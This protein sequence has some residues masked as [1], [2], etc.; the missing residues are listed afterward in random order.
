[1][2]V[3]LGSL[4]GS[5][6]D[7]G[8]LA[9][10]SG[11]TCGRILLPL[12]LSD[13]C[14][15]YGVPS[16]VDRRRRSVVLRF[17]VI[18]TEM[19]CSLLLALA[20]IF[21]FL[22]VFFVVSV[23]GSA[24]RWLLLEG[25]STMVSFAGD[26]TTT[27][28]FFAFV[29]CIVSRIR[30]VLLCAGCVHSIHGAAGLATTERAA[31]GGRK[32]VYQLA[33]EKPGW[34]LLPTC[35]GGSITLWVVLSSGDSE[36]S[37]DLDASD[38][39]S[40]GDVMAESHLQPGRSTFLR[41]VDVLDILTLVAIKNYVSSSGRGA[42]SSCRLLRSPATRMTGKHLQGPSCNFLIP[43]GCLCKNVNFKDYM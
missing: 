17:F 31:G 7:V 20:G 15:G 41:Y 34:S 22:H 14:E 24:V 28:L 21:C 38:L 26:S 9:E 35:F 39:W 19:S 1:M 10:I 43:Q 29:S 36:F 33:T 37:T 13:G 42:A 3:R 8:S 6:G 40:S 30:H 25:W 18:G 5:S 23:G 27:I 2:E 16:C 12:L 4:V 32:M 11:A